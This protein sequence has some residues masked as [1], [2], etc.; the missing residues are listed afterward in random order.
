M[1]DEE[2]AGSSS[3]GRGL[4]AVF[5]EPEDENKSGRL[6]ALIQWRTRIAPHHLRMGDWLQFSLNPKMR[7]RVV[8]LLA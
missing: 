7:M 4:V 2:S 8:G 6:I 5:I 1:E 3:V